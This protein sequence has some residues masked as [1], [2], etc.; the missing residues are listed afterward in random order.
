MTKLTP[1]QIKGLR[2]IRDKKGDFAFVGERLERMG[3]V[4]DIFSAPRLTAAGEAALQAAEM[5]KK[6]RADIIRDSYVRSG[7]AAGPDQVV[8]LT[9][10]KAEI[11]ER[12]APWAVTER[13]EEKAR[14]A[15]QRAAQAYKD[16]SSLG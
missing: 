15:G 8:R 9:R 11:V 13:D 7:I 5:T 2:A 16:G 6:N 12:G 1:A 14:L 4:A 3:L 10:G